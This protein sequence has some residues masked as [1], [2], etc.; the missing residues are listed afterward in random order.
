VSS[1]KV[2]LLASESIF[3]TY[4]DRWDLTPDG[5]PIITHSS[6]LLPVRKHDTLAMLKVAISAEERS[7]GLL[8]AWWNGDG[9]AHVLAHDGDAILLE[10]AKDSTILADLTRRG[11]DDEASHIICAVIAQLHTHGKK[12]FPQLT[13]LT[14]WFR[15]LE[16]A[17]AAYGGI[18]TASA[19]V[20]NEL[21]AHLQEISVLH[22]DIHH[23]NI[24]DF[25]ERGWLAIDP[26]GLIGE[27]YFDYA[28]LF[29]N[30]D[31]ETAAAPDRFARRVEIVTEA[32]GLN[33]NRLLQWILAW[34]GLSAA[35]MIDDDISPGSTLKIAQLA[36]A[37]LNR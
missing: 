22:G 34:S 3:H 26:K 2:R 28:N 5:D 37:E 29:C 31:E 24:L 7:G 33:R 6:R 30:P 16:P 15:R 13:S 17:A 12:P 27:R 8:M 4:L 32:A 25:G 21:L 18:L 10:R 14:Q 36:A 23:G 1:E 11:R 20:A 35:W 19:A 9:A